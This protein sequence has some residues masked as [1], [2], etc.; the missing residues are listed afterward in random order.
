MVL[1]VVFIEKN[2]IFVPLDVTTHDHKYKRRN[3]IFTYAKNM[4]GRNKM[5]KTLQINI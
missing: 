2:A 5:L 1:K 4:K 3:R